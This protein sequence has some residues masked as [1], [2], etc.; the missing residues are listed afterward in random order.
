MDEQN[1]YPTRRPLFSISAIVITTIPIIIMIVGTVKLLLSGRTDDAFVNVGGEI[2]LHLMFCALG[3]PFASMISILAS[4]IAKERGE[5]M[6]VCKSARVYA[7]VVLFVC[8][9]FLAGFAVF[10]LLK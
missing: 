6:R 8:I 4:Y 9:A 1:N 5:S 10:A 7:K 2:L 3:A